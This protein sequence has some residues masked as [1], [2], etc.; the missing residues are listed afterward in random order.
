MRADPKVRFEVRIFVRYWAESGP[1]SR[2]TPSHRT[3]ET[4]D[5][6][7]ALVLYGRLSALINYRVPQLR[8]IL[9]DKFEF[10]SVDE[11]RDIVLEKCYGVFA[12]TET[13]VYPLENPS[14]E[15]KS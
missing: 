13:K 14:S 12:V 15:N 5:L 1:E 10:S 3:F 6:S 7:E 8:D 2:S 4:S 9:R 11:L